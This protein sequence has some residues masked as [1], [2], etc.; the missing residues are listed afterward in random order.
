[1]DE[2]EPPT[3][4]VVGLHGRDDATTVADDREHSRARYL[5]IWSHR[6]VS[7]LRKELS[8]AKGINNVGR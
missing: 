3:L 7:G 1:V 8:K 4:T 2:V 6:A 5:K